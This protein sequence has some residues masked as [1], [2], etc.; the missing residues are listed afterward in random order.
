MRAAR[1]NINVE[2]E[3]VNCVYCVVLE[4]K[5]DAISMKLLFG[6][7]FFAQTDGSESRR[8]EMRVL[9]RF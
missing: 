3:R 4:Q 5:V 9:V 7:E 6:V 2:E 8:E 1:W